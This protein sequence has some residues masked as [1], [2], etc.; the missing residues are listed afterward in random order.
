MTTPVIGNYGLGPGVA[1][2]GAALA[3]THGGSNEGFRAF[4][5]IHPATGD[6]VVVMADGEAGGRVIMEI[7]RAVAKTYGWPDFA[8]KAKASFPLAPETLAARE[9]DWSAIYDGQKITFTLRRQGAGLAFETF[10]GTFLFIP[11]TTPR[12]SPPTPARPPA[13]RSEMMASRSCG[14]SAWR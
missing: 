4:W 12:C 7:V 3:F 9:G 6:G 5:V 14:C 13:S 11:S 1:G 2:E 10:R 8:P